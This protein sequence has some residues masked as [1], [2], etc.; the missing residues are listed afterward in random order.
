MSTEAVVHVGD[1]YIRSFMKAG[2]ALF[3]VVALD[4]VNAYDASSRSVALTELQNAKRYELLYKSV[5]DLPA[6]STPMP[7]PLTESKYFG[8]KQSSP[9]ADFHSR[10]KRFS[11]ESAI[12]H[13]FSSPPSALF[14]D[15]NLFL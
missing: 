8:K 9:S 6:L 5:A 13:V 15:R 3:S 7:S 1:V 4:G 12:A 10:F 2:D 11:D 14:L